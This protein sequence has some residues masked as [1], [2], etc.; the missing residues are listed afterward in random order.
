MT[1]SEVIRRLK[2]NDH[3]SDWS[4]R[5]TKAEIIEAIEYSMEDYEPSEETYQFYAELLQALKGEK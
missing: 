1:K 4:L 3:N 2:A 5:M